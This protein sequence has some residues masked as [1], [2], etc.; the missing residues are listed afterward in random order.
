M[1]GIPPTPTA[2]LKLRGSWRAKSRP[3]EPQPDVGT[4]QCP[5]NLN[6]REREWWDR[7]LPLLT[8]MHV[9][10]VADGE[11]LSR[12]CKLAAKFDTARKTDEMIK[13]TA[14]LDRLGQQFGLTPSS[15][16]R[17]R[18]EP[19]ADQAQKARFFA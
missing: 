6:H 17:I 10:T 2:V 19:K 8:S 7:M 4:P 11:A 3:D 1:S 5:R 9:L 12:Y 14:A 16:A 15:R 18:V 13:L